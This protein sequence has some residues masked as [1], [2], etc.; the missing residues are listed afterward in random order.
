MR[1]T[2]TNIA[3]LDLEPEQKEDRHLVSKYQLV[4]PP[5]GQVQTSVRQD[6]KSCSGD[7]G[8]GLPLRALLDTDPTSLSRQAE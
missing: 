7:V 4:T 8:F 1:D 3:L 2:Q 5:W 6:W